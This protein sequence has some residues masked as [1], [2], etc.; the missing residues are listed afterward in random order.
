MGAL[1]RN[2]EVIEVHHDTIFK[3]DDHVI[4]FAMNKKL[5]PHIEKSFQPIS[6]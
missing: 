3:E 5:I 6:I 2:N 4:M 1:I